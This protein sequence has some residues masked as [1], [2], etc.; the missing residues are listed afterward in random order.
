MSDDQSAR[1]RLP[2][3]AAGQ[4]QKHVTLNETLTR[5][6]ALV[7]MAIVSRTEDNQPT[8]PVEGA[9]YLL[10]PDATGEDWGERDAGDL[11]RHER[12]SWREIEVQPGV[13]AFVVD[14]AELI[15]REAEAWVSLG[16]R[17][18]AVQALTRLGL[19]T[20]ADAANPFA[21]RLNKTLWTAL[22]TSAGGDGDLRFTLNKE[23]AVDVLSLLF[24]SGWGGRAELGLIGDD[25]LRLKVSADGST[26][27][28]AFRIDGVTGRA[29]FTAGA[30]R[31][32]TRT[33]SGGGS[34]SPPPWARTIEAVLVG[35]GGGGGA[36]GFGA[37]GARSGG[38]GGGGGGVT[39]AAWPVDQLS[40][41][42]TVVIGGG[43]G[44]GVAGP[45]AG[46]GLSVVQLAG[47]QLA[48]ADGGA[49]GALAGGDSALQ[50]DAGGPGG[51]GFGAGIDPGGTV[52]VSQS[53]IDGGRL[54]IRA[55]GGAGGS[56]GA[57][58][59][60]TV[61]PRSA[62]HWSGGGGGGGGASVSGAGHAGGAGAWAGGAGGGGGAGL[63]AGG[64]GGDGSS[65]IVWL[66]AI[67]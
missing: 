55:P 29:W 31:R 23:G 52:Q 12:G 5:L 18:G 40:E 34:Y 3:L 63:T 62:L 2:Y 21:A 14:A 37:S 65:G 33:F 19:G 10:P 50:G 16:R 47:A 30:G 25:D 1:L 44:G 43:G 51:G 17:L 28:E 27:R 7:Q 56:G 9:L 11:V 36:G 26:W 49:G 59:A 24:Q 35:G 13:V 38:S 54:A 6:D 48:A 39:F 53:G 57:G 8:A 67:G 66:T 15:V 22:E 46:G 4:M 20:E 64:R 45:G 42:L 60:G 58:S 32:E 61:A 41:A